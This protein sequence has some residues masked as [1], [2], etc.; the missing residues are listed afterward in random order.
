MRLTRNEGIHAQYYIE[1]D[2]SQDDM[3]HIRGLGGFVRFADALQSQRQSMSSTW[4]M[5]AT[6]KQKPVHMTIENKTLDIVEI[7]TGELGRGCGGTIGEES[8][9]CAGIKV[10]VHSVQPRI[11]AGGGCLYVPV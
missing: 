2:P 4:Q 10:G 3:T 9:T 5:L 6:L 11:G 8:I 7:C 1:Q